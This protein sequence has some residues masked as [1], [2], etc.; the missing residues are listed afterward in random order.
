MNDLTRKIGVTASGKAVYATFR[1]V[2][3]KD[4]TSTDHMDAYKLHSGILHEVY[5]AARPDWQEVS[6][7]HLAQ[8]TKYSDLMYA[9]LYTECPLPGYNL[10]GA[11]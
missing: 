6:M 7:H 5:D 10:S 9:C 1:L 4:F 8:I 2:D 3:V 11:A